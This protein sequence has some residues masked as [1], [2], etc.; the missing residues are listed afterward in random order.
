M[1]ISL[2]RVPAVSHHTAL[3]QNV[4]RI[5]LLVYATKRY[6]FRLQRIKCK[7]SI[8]RRCLGTHRTRLAVY[9]YPPCC[10]SERSWYFRTSTQEPTRASSPQDSGVLRLRICGE[11]FKWARI[12]KSKWLVL[13][14][15]EVGTHRGSVLEAG[16]CDKVPNLVE[17]LGTPA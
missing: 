10:R 13:P 3:G 2:S 17:C 4:L 11:Y 7:S 14:K 5:H 15:D 12:L 16:C 9:V 6:T 1:S 8:E